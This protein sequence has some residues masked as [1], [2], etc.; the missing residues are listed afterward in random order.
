MVMLAA[1]TVSALLLTQTARVSAALE[2]TVP[3][4]ILLLT[5]FPVATGAVIA[6]LWEALI[7]AR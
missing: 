6:M 1:A 7:P 2:L 5:N 3:E 4:Y